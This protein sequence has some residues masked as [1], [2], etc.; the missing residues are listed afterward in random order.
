MVWNLKYKNKKEI[1]EIF[2][3]YL[4]PKILEELSELKLLEN[5]HN[6]ILIPIPLS[7]KRFKERGYNQ[8]SLIAKN[9]EKLDKKENFVLEENILFKRKETEHQAR[10]KNKQARLKNLIGTFS[11]KNQELI[12]N[13]NIIL[14]DDVTTTGATLKEARKILRENGAKKI[15]AFTIAH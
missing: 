10:I 11:V 1:A 4:Y 5:F 3:E 12:K 2:T 13:K 8:S 15:I 9:L 14:I 7:K 6:P